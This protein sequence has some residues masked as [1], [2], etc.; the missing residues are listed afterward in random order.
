MITTTPPALQRTTQPFLRELPPPPPPGDM[1]YQ[2]DHI[3]PEEF[4]PAGHYHVGNPEH[5]PAADDWMQDY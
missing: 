4:N 2:Q 3:Y 5:G 1:Y